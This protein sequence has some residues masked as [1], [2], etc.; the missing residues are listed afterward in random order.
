MENN[1]LNN[2]QNNGNAAAQQKPNKSKHHRPHH[3]HR[4][5]NDGKKADITAT[6]ENIKKA[7]QQN[8]P[9]GKQNQKVQNEPISSKPSV[10]SSFDSS[11][12]WMFDIADFDQKKPA[13]EYTFTEEELDAILAERPAVVE[14]DRPRTEVIGIR[15]KKVGKMYYFAPNGINAKV[16]DSAI[17]E[18]AR[19]AEFGQVCLANT[20]VLSD[21]I[22]QP[23]RPV[24]R[25]ATD[26]DK[27]HNEENSAKEA[28]AFRVCIEKIDAHGLDMKL[29]DA[30]YTFDNS[31]LIFYFTSA[32]RV[33]FRDLVKDLASVF[34]T[35]IELRQIG[36]RD[37]AKLMGGL[38]ICG[39]PLCC[40]SHLSDFVQVSIKMAKEQNL[41]LN[42]N[43]ISGTCGR[44]MCC[45]NYEYSTYQQEIAKT[46][47]VDSIVDTPDG[48]GT[49]IEIAPLAGTV[50]VKMTSKQD[51]V[52]K[53]YPR[54]DCK[55]IAK[56]EIKE[57][58]NQ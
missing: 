19:G 51:T 11:P 44:L 1:K 32:G 31:K 56:K 12:D 22:V 4:N 35:R 58:N 29:V 49:I 47:P 38:G 45:L 8:K 42:S 27:A 55:L 39:R 46:P 7:P 52:I 15:F 30:Q 10:V 17:V 23:L 33:D 34:R 36:I 3:R 50:K 43:K 40:A 21:N 28:D 14:D 41:S 54:D 9:D 24:L 5:K 6:N 16:G 53:S 20:R 13:K 37:E 48:R 2:N 26:E 57:E 25:L 18:T